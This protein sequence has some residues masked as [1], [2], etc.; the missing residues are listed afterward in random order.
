MTATAL[1]ARGM[2]F[3]LRFA[4]K[5]AG[6]A[7]SFLFLIVVARTT[8]V[9][10]YGEA[11]IIITIAGFA[12]LFGSLG[13]RFVVLRRVPALFG[14]DRDAAASV[15][16]FSS[17]IAIVGAATVAVVVTVPIY[18]IHTGATAGFGLG[19][20]ALCGALIFVQGAL[21]YYSQL[22]RALGKGDLS[23]YIREVVPRVI[24]ILALGM[25][26]IAANGL[27]AL[28]TV[29]A[30]L[31]VGTV[32]SLLAAAFIARRRL[33]SRDR[34]RAP[35]AVQFQEGVTFLPRLAAATAREYMDVLI[36]SLVAPPAVIAI[37]FT[38]VRFSALLVLPGTSLAT[39]VVVEATRLHSLGERGQAIAAARQLFVQS[40]AVVVPVAAL[41][42]LFSPELLRLFSIS[43]EGYELAIFFV[44]LNG[45]LNGSFIGL[46]EL[47]QC[48]DIG[49]YFHRVFGIIVG[50]GAIGLYFAGSL[51]GVTGLAAAYLVTNAIWIG[52][53]LFELFRRSEGQNGS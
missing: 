10:T 34:A 16:A 3:A 23:V 45:A 17:R 50:A 53:G 6:A 12:S 26:A 41:L 38:L 5:L 33:G 18:L 42:W 25:L 47:M 29:I 13:Q 27:V 19:A 40:A 14:T 35:A 28:T 31:S 1:A 46:W 2:T 39:N 11:A 37:Y 48:L 8:N 9:H 49:R 36:L 21:E 32:L 52:F 24:A 51:G 44:F 4:P 7:I 15:A 22:L 20:L 43:T 30:V